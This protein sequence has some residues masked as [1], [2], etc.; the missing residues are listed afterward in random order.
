MLLQELYAK[1]HLTRHV[2]ACV[3]YDIL[4]GRTTLSASLVC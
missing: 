1:V 4:K 2:M 3:G